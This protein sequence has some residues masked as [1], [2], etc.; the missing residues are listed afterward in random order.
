MQ[1][2]WEGHMSQRGILDSY[3]C[4]SV[5]LGKRQGRTGTHSRMSLLSLLFLCSE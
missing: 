4:S 2:S 3:I 1:D 5:H